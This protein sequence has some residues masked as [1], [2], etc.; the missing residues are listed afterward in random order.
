MIIHP[1]T[2]ERPFETSEVAAE[3][4]RDPNTF[5]DPNRPEM[6]LGCPNRETYD[7]YLPLIAANPGC[8]Y[9]L[10]RVIRVDPKEVLVAMLAC[11]S[12]AADTVP[13]FLRWLLEKYQVTVRNQDG[14]D[15]T[16]FAR[17]E[18]A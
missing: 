8:P 11:G 1:A 6:F 10:V 3:I 13:P 16:E 18:L 17:L 4:L 14:T 9:P 15:L 7:H 5:Q 12:E 2:G